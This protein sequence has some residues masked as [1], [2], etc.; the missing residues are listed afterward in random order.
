MPVLCITLIGCVL[1]PSDRFLIDSVL[2]FTLLFVSNQLALPPTLSDSYTLPEI[3]NF[4]LPIFQA[5]SL[6]HYNLFFYG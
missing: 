3:E 1:P 2:K 6:R 5:K 4:C